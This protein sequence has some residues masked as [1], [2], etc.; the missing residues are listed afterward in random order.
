MLPY[1]DRVSLRRT[2]GFG[3]IVPEHPKFFMASSVYIFFGL[4]LVSMVINVFAELLQSTL[5][6]ARATVGI[7]EDY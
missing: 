6:E 7:V 3:D 4:S 2:V 1:G 5:E